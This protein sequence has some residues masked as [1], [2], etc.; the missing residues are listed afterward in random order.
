MKAKYEK[1]VADIMAREENIWTRG[2][3]PEEAAKLRES[4]RAKYGK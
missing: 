1:K 4:L 2:L 3:T